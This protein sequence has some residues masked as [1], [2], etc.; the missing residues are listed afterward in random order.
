M[1]V[2]V[3]H[4]RLWVSCKAKSWAIR[5]WSWIRLRFQY[6]GQK[7]VLMRRAKLTSI[8][9]SIWKIARRCVAHFKAVMQS[10]MLVQVGR[11]ENAIGWYHSHPG[12]G[13]W[14]SGIDVNTQLNNQSYQDPFVAVVVRS[15]NRLFGVISFIRCT[16]LIP[17][18]LS[19]LAKWTLALSV[20]IP[21]TIRRP[22]HQAQNTSLSLS[23]RL[24]TL[25][26]MQISI[27]N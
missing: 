11:L 20:L 22:A 1:R 5:L 9:S 15:T 7:H 12:Y 14:L 26:Y 6:K 27:T 23:V 2:L 3:S 18:V 4:M 16:R 25:E 21:R 10:S 8:W 13:C 19:L 24:R 17:T